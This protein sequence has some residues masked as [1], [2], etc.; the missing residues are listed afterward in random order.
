[1]LSDKNCWERSSTIVCI[2]SSFILNGDD[3]WKYILMH[4]MMVQPHAVGMLLSYLARIPYPTV[5]GYL[6][7]DKYPLLW[8]TMSRQ[9]LVNPWLTIF[10]HH[11]STLLNQHQT[12]HH[13]PSLTILLTTSYQ[14]SHQC[15]TITVIQLAITSAWPVAYNPLVGPFPDVSP[16]LSPPG[17]KAAKR[18][19]CGVADHEELL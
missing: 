19:T 4:N 8:T 11:S 13:Q 18:C 3:Y 15:I 10:A 9:Y 6:I 1:M 17:W 2:V 16:S 5:V 12:A 14:H 7:V